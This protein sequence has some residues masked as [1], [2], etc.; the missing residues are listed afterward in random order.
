MRLASL[1]FGKQSLVCSGSESGYDAVAQF[2]PGALMP[3][4]QHITSGALRV[5]QQDPL[6]DDRD[7]DQASGSF[8]GVVHG[9]A[10][11]EMHGL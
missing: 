5:R 10:G 3:C 4:D 6:C 1:S 7:Q 8:L 11:C 2:S 9:L